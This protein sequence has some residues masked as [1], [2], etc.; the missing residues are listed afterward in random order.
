MDTFAHTITPGKAFQWEGEGIILTLKCVSTETTGKLL[1]R[2]GGLDDFHTIAIFNDH[3]PSTISMDL[4]FIEKVDFKTEGCSVSIAGIVERADD[5]SDY[6][7]DEMEETPGLILDSDT[8]DNSGVESEDEQQVRIE[9]VPGSDNETTAIP[10]ALPAEPAEKEVE[11]SEG[12]ESTA[13]SDEEEPAREAE[14][15]AAALKTTQA[16]APIKAK[17]DAKKDEPKPTTVKKQAPKDELKRKAHQGKGQQGKGQQAKAH[18]GKPQQGKP[19][20]GKGKAQPQ[21]NKGKNVNKGKPH[22]KKNVQR[23]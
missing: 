17:I 3:T 21:G 7:D 1:V 15:P 9:E 8:T 20:Q 10:N 14:Q 18:Q 16:S 6:S 19:Q 13:D 11:S 5:A 4:P 23:Q 12:E 2:P 22:Q